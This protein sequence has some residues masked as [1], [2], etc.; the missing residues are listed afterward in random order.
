MYLIDRYAYTNRLREVDPAQK[1]SLAIAVLLL[2]LLLD[3]PSVGLF[4]V[5]WMWGIT[6][7][8][9]KIPNLVF[10]KILLAEGLFLL[11][12]G[13]GIAFSIN[14][15]PQISPNWN[16]QIGWF[17]LSSNPLAVETA[18]R[19]VFRAFGGA[20]AMNFLILTTPL[21]DQ[22]DLLHRMRVPPL[23]IDLMTLIY[24][25]IFIL[26]ASLERMYT[27]QDCRLGYSSFWRSMKSASLLGSR[28]FIEAYHRSQRLHLALESRGYTGDLV[29]LPHS[30]RH[31]QR[32]Y[33]LGI[34]VILSFIF[35][36]LWL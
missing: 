24:R 30:Y 21:V 34:S 7:L 26:L 29:F 36:R 3:R 5:F 16:W 4:A 14:F 33:L 32:F 35:A 18:L 10:G 17:W 27:A 2:C 15:A 1:A 20:A 23:L 9:A 28:L 31:D 25:S 12:A 6:T 11:V 19:A 13:L 22:I 8:W